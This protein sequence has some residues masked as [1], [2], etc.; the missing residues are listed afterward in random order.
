[1]TK[2]T[3]LGIEK[4]A[5]FMAGQKAMQ[6][7]YD[8]CKVVPYTEGRQI[9]SAIEKLGEHKHIIHGLV[10][11]DVTMVRQLIHD[12]E[13]A[14]G[15]DISLTAFINTCL[16]KA[17]AM[18]ERVHAYRKGASQL[19]LFDDVDVNIAIEREVIGE[20]VPLTHIIRAADKKEYQDLNEETHKAQ[21]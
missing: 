15:T 4:R 6:K 8:G 7:Q 14:T 9:V 18:I 17:V 21:A 16:G 10:E 12:Y 1:M 5:C 13:A 3:I 2:E 19:F 11:V 20:K